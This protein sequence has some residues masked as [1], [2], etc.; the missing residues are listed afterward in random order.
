MMIKS[1][2]EQATYIHLGDQ[3]TD[4]DLVKVINKEQRQ[5]QDLHNSPTDKRYKTLSLEIDE[6]LRIGGRPSR[7]CRRQTSTV[8]KARS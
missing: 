2:L 1:V 8:R 3:R 7:Y 5:V 6:E 4:D